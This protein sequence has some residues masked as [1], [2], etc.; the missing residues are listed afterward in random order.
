M[1]KILYSKVINDVKPTPE[2]VA[3]MIKSLAGHISF[4]TSIEVVNKVINKDISE[5]KNMG[6]SEHQAS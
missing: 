2:E 1:L 6:F 3:E 5:A 4:N